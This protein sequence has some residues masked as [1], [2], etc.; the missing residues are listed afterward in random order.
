MQKIQSQLQR[1]IAIDISN[2]ML[3]LAKE[4]QSSLEHIERQYIHGDFDDI[5]Q[6]K[7]KMNISNLIAIL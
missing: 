6:I 2:Q 4:N 3:D 1:Y 5:F 7:S